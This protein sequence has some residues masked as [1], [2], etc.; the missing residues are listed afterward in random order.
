MAL[1]HDA[2]LGD[3]HVF[4]AVHFVRLPGSSWP[5]VSMDFAVDGHGCIPS[6]IGIRR[7]K[8]TIVRDDDLWAGISILKPGL[9]ILH[10]GGNDV[11]SIGSSPLPQ[12]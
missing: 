3:S 7:G 8:L 10:L 6:F 5:G 2:T 9:V 11:D 1:D 12:V 4:W